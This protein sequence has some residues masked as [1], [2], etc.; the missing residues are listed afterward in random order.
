MQSLNANAPRETHHTQSPFLHQVRS[1]PA[2]MKKTVFDAWNGYHSVALHPDDRHLTTLITPWGRYRYRVAPQ[3]YVASSD[4]YSRRFDEIVSD[5]PDKTK[6]IDD[7][8]LWAT[9]LEAR[10]HQ[11][12]KWL[13]LCGRIKWHY[14]FGADTVEFAGFEVTHDSVRPSQKYLRAFRSFPTPQDITDIRS[15]FGLINPVA[16]TF[17]MTER[18]SPFR[19]LLKPDTPFQW[20]DTLQK[21]FKEFKTVI[22]DE[23][24]KDV[25]IFDKT[26]PRFLVTDWTK[27]GIGFWL[28]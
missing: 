7:S 16:Y 2:G 18:M 4:G 19:S 27:D 25:N 8:L 17:S 11:A 10:F 3:G 14:P 24:C 28:L 9:D 15:W 26:K 23:I 5:V 1:A 21:L 6:C 12:T 13:E 20:D 22:L